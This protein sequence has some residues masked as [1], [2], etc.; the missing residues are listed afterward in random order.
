MKRFIV[1]TAPTLKISF[2]KS[3]FR[4]D[5]L[6][7]EQKFNRGNNLTGYEFQQR[8]KR[9]EKFR[10]KQERQWYSKQLAAKELKLD[11]TNSK[12]WQNIRSKNLKKFIRFGITITVIKMINF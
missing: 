2:A 8:Q 3:S 12:R 9:G 4:D 10:T 5:Q 1:F 6:A 11:W 7:V